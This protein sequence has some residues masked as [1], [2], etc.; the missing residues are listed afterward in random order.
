MVSHI[1]SEHRAC[2]QFKSSRRHYKWP[3]NSN[4]PRVQHT[5]VIQSLLYALRILRSH[6]IPEASLHDVAAWCF[7]CSHHLE[8]DLLRTVMVW[9]LS[10]C[11][12][13]QAGIIYQPM[14]ETWLLQLQ[15]AVRRLTCQWW[16]WKFF[17]MH[18][19]LWWIR[20]TI[21]LTWPSCHSISLCERTHNK[22]L[23]SKTTLLSVDDFLIRMLYEDLYWTVYQ[24]L[25]STQSLVW[26]ACDNSLINKYVM[27]WCYILE[28]QVG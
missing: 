3:A 26:V 22:T 5:D 21:T 27:W 18:D 15:P 19:H 17:Q 10:R 1:M 9:C 12:P 4:Q 20:S 16:W 6:S 11:W 23:I 2:Q 8:A 25:F 7:P 24:H 14:Q 13:Y 28:I